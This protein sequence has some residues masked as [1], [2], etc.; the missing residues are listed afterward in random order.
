VGPIANEVSRGDLM[1][2]IQERLVRLGLRPAL[3]GIF[4]ASCPDRLRVLI[5]RGLLRNPDGLRRLAGCQ[6]RFRCFC[7]QFLAVLARV[8]APSV[9]VLRKHSSYPGHLWLLQSEPDSHFSRP[10]F[11]VKR[12]ESDKCASLV[13]KCKAPQRKEI[14]PTVEP[15]THLAQQQNRGDPYRGEHDRNNHVLV[16]GEPGTLLLV[17]THEQ[18]RVGS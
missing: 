3:C 5:H 13:K 18:R 1:T 15:A 9:S 10:F 8:Q 7:P 14:I 12:L 16:I 6:G 2:A 17:A 11:I 4:P